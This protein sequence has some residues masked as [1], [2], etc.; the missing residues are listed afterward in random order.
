MWRSPNRYGILLQKR[1]KVD[2]NQGYVYGHERDWKAF[3][4][5]W[6]QLGRRIR[7]NSSQ[8]NI[9]RCDVLPTVTVYSCRS[10][11]RL[12]IA[13][14]MCMVMRGTGKRLT[15]NMVMIGNEKCLNW[16]NRFFILIWT[17][18]GRYIRRNSS[19]DNIWRCDYLPTLTVYSCISG[20]RFTLTIDGCEVMRGNGK[21]SNWINRLYGLVWTQ[22]GRYIRTNSSRNNIWRCASLPNRYGILLQKREKVGPNQSCVYGHETDLEAFELE[23]PFLWSCLHPVGKIIY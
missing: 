1:E 18:L 14:A 5:V 7:R 12:T 16:N 15:R 21:H 9:W 13:R 8:S 10:G 4:L 6:T 17:R 3:D 19:L 23:Q 22:L 20:R 11:R 2:H